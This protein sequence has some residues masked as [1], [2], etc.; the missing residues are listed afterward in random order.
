MDRC[1]RAALPFQQMYSYRC[2]LRQV[3][4]PHQG[5]IYRCCFAVILLYALVDVRLLTSGVTAPSRPC[6]VS[7]SHLGHPWSIVSIVR[8]S[9]TLRVCLGISQAQLSF[10]S[11]SVS[12]FL[13]PSCA[14]AIPGVDGL[15][16]VEQVPVLVDPV[17]AHTLSPSVLIRESHKLTVVTA[18]DSGLNSVWVSTCRAVG[19][20]DWTPVEGTRR[21]TSTTSCF[22]CTVACGCFSSPLNLASSSL[23]LDFSQSW[24][25]AASF[26][27]RC[28]SCWILP[29]WTCSR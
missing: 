1:G 25:V 11:G 28:S 5:R 12:L 16:L 29:R 15:V 6:V 13:Q 14:L 3:S 27:L 9:I 4:V 18:V 7:W 22:S 23:R 17:C 21:Q 10:A 2:L 20:L 19:W 24:A 8:F 26:L